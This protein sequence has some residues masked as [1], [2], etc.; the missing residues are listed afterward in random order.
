M[1]GRHQI[2]GMAPVTI[3]TTQFCGY[4]V[5][6]KRLFE[7]L[8]YR[9][10]EVRLDGNW[11]L[12][13]RLSRETGWRTVPMIFIGGRFVGGFDDV[14]ELHRANQL[15]PLLEEAGAEQRA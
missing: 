4:C 9:F 12:R 15:A 1:R 10:E 8:G 5:R 14:H 13:E 11:E 2:S 7:T 3:Y 6:A